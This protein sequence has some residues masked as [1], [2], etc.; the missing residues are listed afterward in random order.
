M[1]V[2]TM[3]ASAAKAALRIIVLLGATAAMPVAD[4]APCAG[5]TDVDDS[6]EFCTNVEWL[7]NRGITI[8]C[9]SVAQFCPIDNVTRLT[10]AVFLKRLGNALTPRN[11]TSFDTDVD[12]D[13]DANPRICSTIDYPAFSP[14][15]AHGVAVVGA[16]HPDGVEFAVEIVESID[17]GT[18]WTAVTPLHAVTAKANERKTASVLVPP[19]E[20]AVGTAYRYAVR[21]S[22]APGSSITADAAFWQC[23]LHLKLDNRNPVMPPL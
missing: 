13:I 4:A 17:A 20:L 9:T 23:Q 14:Q 5:F 8:G 1:K 18:T 22:R 21:V 12:L 10:M 3:R 19:R 7:T 11:V 2:M 15:M 6:S 16:G